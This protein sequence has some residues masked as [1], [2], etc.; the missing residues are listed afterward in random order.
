MH[1]SKGFFCLKKIFE[2]RPFFI[3]LKKLHFLPHFVKNHGEFQN[4]WSTVYYK[5]KILTS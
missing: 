3:P 5:I 2:G 4:A 1:F